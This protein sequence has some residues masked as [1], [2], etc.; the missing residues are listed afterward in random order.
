MS[1][2]GEAL[3]VIT[4]LLGTDGPVSFAGERFTLD[5]LPGMASSRT[6][7]TPPGRDRAGRS[8][9]R[10]AAARR[11]LRDRLAAGP[12]HDRG[13]LRPTARGRPARRRG[14]RPGIR[15]R[16]SQACTSYAVIHDDHDVAAEGAL[17]ACCSECRH[18]GER[19]PVR[20]GGA[21]APARTGLRRGCA[22][23]SR[24]GVLGKTAESAERGQRPPGR[25]GRALRR[26]RD[27]GRDRGRSFQPFVDVGVEPRGA[28][29]PLAAGDPRGARSGQPG[30]PRRDT[31]Q[32]RLTFRSA[33]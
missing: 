12:A 6:A 29:Q 20:A 8:L 26:A 2:L 13:P 14:G 24:S 7:T 9:R 32:P 10:A 31:D 1:R 11:P 3:E 4:R 27:A 21:R 16:S 19:R 30:D 17:K 18:R 28:R 15:R 22:T 33:P 25:G 5:R 23:T